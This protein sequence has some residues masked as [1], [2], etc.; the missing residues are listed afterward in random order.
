M[1]PTK[2]YSGLTRVPGPDT[3]FQSQASSV[4]HEAVLL[5]DAVEQFTETRNPKPQ[6]AFA[7]PSRAAG[8]PGLLPGTSWLMVMANAGFAAAICRLGL[9]VSCHSRY[10]MAFTAWRSRAIT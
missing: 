6:T 5:P 7:R 8:A 4:A 3:K 1:I 9:V 2:G 10:G